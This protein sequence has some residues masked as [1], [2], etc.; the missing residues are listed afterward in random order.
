MEAVMDEPWGDSE[1]NTEDSPVEKESV[2]N[3]D[4][5]KQVKDFA[6]LTEEIKDS[7]EALNARLAAGKTALIDAGFNKHALE[8]AIKYARTPE[9][10]RENF[11]LSYLY[12][13]R[14]L[15]VPVQDDLFAAAVGEQV[16]V[17]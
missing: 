8:A 2:W 14:A 5:L 7:R 11:D 17:G 12:C 3:T 13:R 1:P 10:K 16:K 4:T 9:E 6:D 15:G